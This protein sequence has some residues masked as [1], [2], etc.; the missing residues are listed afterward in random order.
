MK[1]LSMQFTA[2]FIEIYQMEVNG[3]NAVVH[4]SLYVPM[5]ANTYA[6]GMLINNDLRISELLSNTLKEEKIKDKKVVVTVT[7][8][9]CLTE[10]FSLP[11]GKQRV[12]DG[13]VQQELQKRRKLNANYIYDYIV[14]GDDPLKNGCVLI[15]AVL[16]PK[17][18]IAN[19]FDVI[20][21]AG[22]EPYRIDLISHSMELLAER[23]GLLSSNEISILACINEDEIHFLYCGKNEEPYYRHAVIEQGDSLEESM[24]VLSAATKIDLGIDKDENLI[25]KVIEN[26]TRLSRFHSQRHPDVNI[27]GVLIYGNYPNITTLCDRVTHGVGIPAKVYNPAGSITGLTIRQGRGITKDITSIGLSLFISDQSQQ[28]QFFDE[29]LKQKE[30][31]HR[32]LMLLPIV[33]AL[34]AALVVVV[35]YQRQVRENKRL[36][37]EIE[38]LEITINDPNLLYEYYTI[39]AAIIEADKAS[40][41]ADRGEAYQAK[42]TDGSR[43]KSDYIRIIDKNTPEGVEISEYSLND[44]QITITC[45]GNNQYLP[46]AFTE[47]LSNLPEFCEVTYGG[48]Q[49]M[50]TFEGNSIYSFEITVTIAKVSEGGTNR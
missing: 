43:F 32:D 14:L 44:G 37:N 39:D 5:P 25:E 9:D 48:F 7:P 36:A 41:Y 17:N 49:Q 35:L 8:T 18:L 13:M 21:K 29:F 26:V 4:N 1:F 28:Y 23:S 24:F 45:T 47:I 34:F 27:R 11:K 2:N 46:A 19:Y 20:K 42:L 3:R 38:D 30:G 50:L 33:I 12:L 31:K 15:R 16:F 10:E 40:R 6:S 22:L